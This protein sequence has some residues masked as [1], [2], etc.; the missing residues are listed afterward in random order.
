MVVKIVN[1]ELT[2][3]LGSENYDLNYNQNLRH[4]SLLVCKVLEKQQHVLNLQNGLKKIKK[5]KF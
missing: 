5:R 2:N 1:D 4:P 3:L